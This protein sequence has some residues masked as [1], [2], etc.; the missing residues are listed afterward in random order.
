MECV[1]T[2]RFS[3]MMSG[4]P[5]GFFSSK[6]GVRQVDPMPSY[7]FVLALEYLS[8]MMKRLDSHPEFQY[9]PKYKDLKLIH[10]CFADDMMFVCRVDHTSP[11]LLKVIFDDFSNAS[12]LQINLQK[13][14]VFFSGTEPSL[15]ESI[16]Q[17]LGFVKG[18][19]KG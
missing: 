2:I 4:R 15:N 7:L 9:H 1:R 3:I 13:L 16:F 14:Y 19:M 11:A 12:G 8:R 18:A 6:R 5:L 17:K 10:L